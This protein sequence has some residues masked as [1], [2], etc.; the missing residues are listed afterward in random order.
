MPTWESAMPKRPLWHL[1]GHLQSNKAKYA[2]SLFDLIQSVD[3][4]SLAQEIGRQAVKLGK[5]PQAVLI[6]VNLAPEV[7]GRAGVL[8]ETVN[9]LAAQIRETPG[10]ELQ[11]LMGI[12]PASPVADGGDPDVDRAAETARAH[13][14]KLRGLWETLPDQN[15]R[16]L[17]MGMSGDFE[18]AIEEGATLIRIGTA[19]FGRRKV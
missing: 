9:D 18:T 19:I 14:R 1:I 10:L 3:S 8:P 6:E 16:I 7:L 2:V 5:Q 12:A 13:F 4:L 17:S 11:G 15:R